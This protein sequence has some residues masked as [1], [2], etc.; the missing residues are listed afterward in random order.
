M[1]TLYITACKFIASQDVTIGESVAALYGHL[2]LIMGL[3]S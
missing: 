3:V 2:H 1:L